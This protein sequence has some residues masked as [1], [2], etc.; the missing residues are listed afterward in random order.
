MIEKDVEVL[1]AIAERNNDGDAMTRKTTV[2]PVKPSRKYVLRVALLDS[3][4]ILRKSER[5]IKT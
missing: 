1:G 3:L 4:R 2:R 5:K